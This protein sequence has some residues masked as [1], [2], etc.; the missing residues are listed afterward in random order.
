MEE[1]VIIKGEQG[2]RFILKLLL[3]IAI[4]AILIGLLWYFGEP[5]RTEQ[6]KTWGGYWKTYEYKPDLIDSLIS[7]F[8]DGWAILIDG[9]ILIVIV[10]L[11]LW[12]WLFLTQLTVTDKRAYGKAAFGKRV[13]LPIDSVSSIG[14]SFPKCVSI[15]TSSGKIS[16]ELLKNQKAVH[17]AISRLL[18]ERQMRSEQAMNRSA[19]STA[20]ELRKYKEL[21]DGGVISQEE[22]DAK[23]K[24]LLEV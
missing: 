18:I 5:L 2:S 17:T 1:K 22:F 9:G 6:R 24:Q 23:K 16:F 10:S 12:W 19:V 8:D 21:L 14:M 13:D 20:D 3:G 15:G 11:I 4:S 7:P